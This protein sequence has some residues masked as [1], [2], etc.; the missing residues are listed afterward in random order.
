MNRIVALVPV[1]NGSDDLPS[2]LES[3]RHVADTVLAMDD[4]STDDTYDLLRAAPQ[5]ELV[6][7]NPRRPTYSGWDDHANRSRLLAA[8]TAYEPG[9]IVWF[10]ADELVDERDAIALR[11]FLL[12]GAARDA[13]Y[14]VRVF[15]MI[16]DLSTYDKEGLWVYRVFAFR[17]GLTLPE[18]KLHF[19]PIP[20]QISST[21]WRKTTVRLRHLA[22]ITEKRRRERYQK[23]EEADPERRWQ[24]SYE[25]LLHPPG[26]RK[27]WVA[28]PPGLPV[29][30]DDCSASDLSLFQ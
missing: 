23:Y 28:R 8:S 30:L 22:G 12:N 3:I 21:S 4:G 7:R 13:A 11:R 17:E 2:Y 19:E 1:R 5:V 14:G 15:R 10:D 29:L 26:R 18:D 9:W 25:N 20:V 6:L 27:T 24:A 16:D